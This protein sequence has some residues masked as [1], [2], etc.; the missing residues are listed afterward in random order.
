M[1]YFFIGGCPRSGTTLVQSILCSDPATNPLIGEVGYLYHLVEAYHS[2]KLDFESQGRYFFNDFIDLKQFS[3]SLVQ[4]FLNQLQKHYTDATDLVLKHPVLSRFFPDVYELLEE[5]V[6]FIVVIRDPRDTISS[7]I[8]VGERMK[9][10][11]NKRHLTSLFTQRNM[12]EY[13]KFYQSIYAPAW[14]FKSDDFQSKTCY[15][16]YE[17]L[18]C[19]P[20]SAL[21][22]LRN[23]TGLNLTPS[24][25]EK[26]WKRNLVE[27]SQL[28]D[29]AQPFYSDL[30]GQPISQT[31]IQ[32]YQQVL[33]A[34]EIDFIEHQGL[35]IFKL[36][37]YPLSFD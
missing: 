27:H 5:N 28:Q 6:K 30:Y 20:N 3:T 36:F 15:I 37:G 12:A 29:A 7:L 1:T 9:Q 18:V 16:K 32:K 10:Q 13:L 25:V 35:E 2:A 17:Y 19:D 22:D 4:S 33:N 21:Q 24:D 26:V 8:Q 11:G 31:R 14:N 23:F 34:D